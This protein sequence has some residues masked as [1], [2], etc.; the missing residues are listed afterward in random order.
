MKKLILSLLFLFSASLF[1]QENYTSVGFLNTVLDQNAIRLAIDYSKKL[2]PKLELF[3]AS[4]N[5]LVSFSPNLQVLTGG[6]D[7]FSGILIGYTGNFMQFKTTEVAGITTP[8]LS[9][10][11]HNFPVT[12]GVETSDQVARINTLVEGGYVPMFRAKPAASDFA[13]K[14]VQSVKLGA[15]LQ[16]G[17][18]FSL[19]EKA[20]TTIGGKVDESQEMPDEF[21]GRIKL[22]AKLAP[23]W[24]SEKG[25]GF[26]LRADGSLW[27][28]LVN[29]ATYYRVQGAGRIIITPKYF[30]DF[31]YEKGS[32]APNFNE[33]EQWSANL[34]ITF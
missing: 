25:F 27:F 2:E 1:S 16:G 3:K 12:V 33:G 30:F 24:V 26:S 34:G 15:F 10:T 32:G 6:Q 31:S 19:S 22:R 5:G 17:Y 14:F 29:G 28:D 18:K 20:L 9:K 13:K 8:D 21:L 23:K 7:A 4:D 11:F